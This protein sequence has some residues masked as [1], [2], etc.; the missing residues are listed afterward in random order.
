MITGPAA[1]QQVGRRGHQSHPQHTSRRQ[2]PISVNTPFF[3]PGSSMPICAILHRDV[4]AHHLTSSNIDML[5]R[6]LTRH[7]PL[8]RL[9]S[10]SQGFESPGPPFPWDWQQHIPTPS[11]A[12]ARAPSQPLSP[13]S[14]LGWPHACRPLGA[15]TAQRR[16]QGTA[17]E[18]TPMSNLQPVKKDQGQLSSPR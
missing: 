8:I 9:L 18:L 5:T 6:T 1:A 17:G 7:S 11:A 10:L 14:P 3:H 13:R 2:A 4:W 12:A 15:G 16:R